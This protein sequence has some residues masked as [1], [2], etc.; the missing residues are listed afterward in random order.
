MLSGLCQLVSATLQLDLLGFDPNLSALAS[1]PARD[2]L[3][4]LFF[5]F[6]YSARANAVVIIVA[7]I[8]VRE[9]ATVVHPS[10]MSSGEG[11]SGA[12][13]EGGSE[14][15]GIGETTGGDGDS[16]GSSTVSLESKAI[17]PQESDLSVQE[18]VLAV[19][20]LAFLD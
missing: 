13:M 9:T 8:V 16:G 7:I 14:G 12:G 18:T 15:V 5:R 20:E 6:L 19:T 17:S 3:Y 10:T 4:Y 1:I 11:G 2:L